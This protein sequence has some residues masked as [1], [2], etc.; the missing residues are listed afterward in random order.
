VKATV[1]ACASL[2]YALCLVRPNQVSEDNMRTSLEPA[3]AAETDRIFVIESDEVVRSALQ[4]ILKDP[5]ETR[6]FTDLNQAVA[7]D[8][9][10]APDVVLLG[11]DLLRADGRPVVEQ[12]ARRW[13][14]A[15]ILIVANSVKDLLALAAL[16]WGAHDVLGK[17]INVRRR[18]CQGRRSAP[19]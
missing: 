2:R 17:P 3:S 18:S 19:T 6:G 4:F 10:F 9:D 14:G 13:D 15:K 7:G 8:A 5:G 1:V 12:I 16:K 11:I